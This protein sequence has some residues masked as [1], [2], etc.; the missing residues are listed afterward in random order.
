MLQDIIDSSLNTALPVVPIPEIVIPVSMETYGFA[1]GTTLGLHNSIFNIY[2][3]TI[4]L[5]GDF[6]E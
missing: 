1:T 5:E 6:S 4:E 3:S 2:E